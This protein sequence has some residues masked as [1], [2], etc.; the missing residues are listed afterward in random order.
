MP[1]KEAASSMKRPKETV[2]KST[3]VRTVLGLY[4]SRVQVAPEAE[5]PLLLTFNK[6]SA[7]PSARREIPTHH[8]ALR[9]VLVDLPK[10][11]RRVM[12]LS[13]STQTAVGLTPCKGKFCSRKNA[14]RRSNLPAQ[15]THRVL[16]CRL[17]PTLAGRDLT[18][19]RL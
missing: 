6:S 8:D 11:G 16:K 13:A 2:C 19:C 3:D 10:D 7:A 1:Q 14:N 18:F 17:S 15:Q 12:T 5:A 4:F 9:V